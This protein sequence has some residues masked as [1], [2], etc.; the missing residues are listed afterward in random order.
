MNTRL[1]YIVFALGWLF[2]LISVVCIGYASYIAIC[3]LSADSLGMLLPPGSLN[4][5]I[6]FLYSSAAVLVT[7]VLGLGIIRV[8]REAARLVVV[9]FSINIL[10]QLYFAIVLLREKEEADWTICFIDI[11]F[12]AFV[13]WL[14]RRR[15]VTELFHS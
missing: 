3:L 9:A 13:I 6:E 8:R 14:F 12:S 7:F 2:I 15:D 11:L 5:R 4:Q 10:A 1:K